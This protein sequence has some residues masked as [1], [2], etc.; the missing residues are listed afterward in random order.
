MFNGKE[1][2]MRN[3]FLIVVLVF[4]S[5]AVYG[6]A[7]FPVTNKRIVTDIW[8]DLLATK[9]SEDALYWQNM[10]KKAMKKDRDYLMIQMAHET[11]VYRNLC[12][13]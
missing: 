12:I 5:G 11:N 4:F 7:T 2:R 3:F 13:K 10:W 9:L 8:C 6:Q 1:I